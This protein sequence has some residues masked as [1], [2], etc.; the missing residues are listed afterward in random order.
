MHAMAFLAALALVPQPQTLVEKGGTTSVTSV[1][2]TTDA[3]IPAEGYRLSVGAE[4]VTVASS[5]AAGAFYARQ[6]LEQLKV[7]GKDGKVTLPCVEIAD[8]PEFKWRGILI[9]ECRHFFG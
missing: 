5:G 2:E 6:T 8:A 3:K 4:G 1:T 7:R 9:D